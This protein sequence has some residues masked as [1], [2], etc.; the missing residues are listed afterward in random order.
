MV[1]KIL[2]SS[3][4]FTQEQVGFVK[5]MEIYSGFCT[6]K[7]NK[8]ELMKFLSCMDAVFKL[9]HVEVAREATDGNEK[10]KKRWRNF[11]V[12][13]YSVKLKKR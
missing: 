10:K 2:N 9:L 7:R 13:V 6:R 4:R 11:V 8:V 5:I 3:S 1:Q 12:G